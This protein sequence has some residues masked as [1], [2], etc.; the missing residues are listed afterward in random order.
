L[1]YY[2]QESE[3]PQAGDGLFNGNY[4]ASAKLEFEPTQELQLGLLYVHSYNESNLATGTGSLRSQLDLD[5]PV[6]GNSYSLEASWNVNKNFAIGGWVGFTD[7]KV[8]D[9]G[10]ADVWNYALTVAFPD[11][12]QNGNLLGVVI[13]QEPTLTSTSGF[14]INNRRSD[15]NTSLHL[16]AFYRHQIRNNLSITPGLIWITSP[17]GDNDNGELVVFT[18]RTTFEF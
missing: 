8:I 11:L 16:E 5:R 3:S 9:L 4:S 7:A 15:P 2:N 10:E 12:G 18:L 6:V 1:E 13:G 14:L 17:N